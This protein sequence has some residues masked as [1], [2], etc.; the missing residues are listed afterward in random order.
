MDL[1]YPGLECGVEHLTVLIKGGCQAKNNFEISKP[2]NIHS[3][4]IKNYA[5]TAKFPGC[6][7]HLYNFNIV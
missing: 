6:G 2:R 7:F 4:L 1:W 5:L 3:I